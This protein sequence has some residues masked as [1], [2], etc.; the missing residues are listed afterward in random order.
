MV[1]ELSGKV[2]LS[3][4]LLS[5]PYPLFQRYLQSKE[6]ILNLSMKCWNSAFHAQGLRVII[7]VVQVGAVKIYV[8]AALEGL[9]EKGKTSVYHQNW[10]NFNQIITC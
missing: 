6:H 7:V 4:G 10:Q 5:P 9:G 8:A 3:L 1:M 2:T